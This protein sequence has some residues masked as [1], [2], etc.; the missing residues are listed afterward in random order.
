MISTLSRNGVL[1]RQLQSAFVEVYNGVFNL[2]FSKKSY[3]HDR[4]AWLPLTTF[5]PRLPLTKCLLKL[6]AD[7]GTLTLISE[8][9]KIPMSSLEIN[10]WREERNLRGKLEYELNCIMRL[11]RIHIIEL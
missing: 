6:Q 9:L 11:Q 10:V 1:F 5:L 8:I 7:C 4:T 3:L 2:V